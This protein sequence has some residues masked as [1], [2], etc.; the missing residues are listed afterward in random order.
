MQIGIIGSGAM[1]SGIAQLAATASHPTLIFDNNPDALHRSAEKTAKGLEALVQKGKISKEEA[2]RIS[3]NLTYVSNL[4][5]FTNCGL[6]IEA[7]IEDLEVKKQVFR[8]LEM[9]VSESCILATNTSSLSVTSIA[10]ACKLPNRFIGIHF[11]NPAMIMPLVEIIPGIQTDKANIQIAIDVIKS[12]GKTVV[13][14]KDTPGF[15]VNRVARPYYSESFKMME[16]GLAD[17]LTIDT[18]LKEKGGFKMGPFE[19]TDFI[20]HDVNYAVTESVWTSFYFD[21]RYRPSISQ[22]RLVEAGYLGKKTGQ[23]FYSYTDGKITEQPKILG[24]MGEPLAIQIFERVLVMLI[25]EAADAIY[26]NITTEVDLETAMTKGVN[27]P[28]GL[29][30]WANEFGIEK[31]VKILDTLFINYHDMRYRVCP[32][33]REMAQNKRLF[34]IN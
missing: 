10:P 27:Y 9:M 34:R 6:V 28:K 7:I 5:E 1:G 21:P 17:A 13:I 15:I 22:K 26:M 32:L 8:E 23:G 16:E 4:S 20:G 2:Q 30:A 14:A 12:W 18:V 25:N 33:L 19:L 11:F 24:E 31:T 3:N 29:L